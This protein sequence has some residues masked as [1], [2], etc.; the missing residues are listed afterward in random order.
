V[1]LKEQ[2]ATDFAKVFLNTDHFAEEILYRPSGGA[3]VTITALVRRPSNPRER[4]VGKQAF[5]KRISIQ[6]ANHATLGRTTINT[7]GDQVDVKLHPDD[8]APITWR[9]LT[10]LYGDSGAW[11]LEVGE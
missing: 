6:I 1:T 3:P 10:K 11:L 2:L 8:A 9:V 5:Q 7:S 4:L